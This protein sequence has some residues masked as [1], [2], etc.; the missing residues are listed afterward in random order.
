MRHVPVQPSRTARA[1]VAALVVSAAASADA[2]ATANTVPTG[3]VCMTYDAQSGVAM[4]RFGYDNRGVAIENILAGDLNFFQP[5]PSDRSQPNQF[6]PG[7]G[8]FDTSISATSQPMNWWINS[9]Y[10]GTGPLTGSDVVFDRPCPERGPSITAVAPT[11]LAPGGG[12]Q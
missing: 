6:I 1:A 9:V 11:A 3:L 10:S 4:P 5:N 2:L 8:T 12:P 7:N